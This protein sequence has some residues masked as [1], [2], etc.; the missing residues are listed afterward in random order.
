[1]RFEENGERIQDLKLILSRV[2]YASTLFDTDGV[3]IRFMNWK[4][5]DMR[6]L[7]NIKSEQQIEQL[8]AGGPNSVQFAG[9]T[10]LG[11]E[12]RNQVINPLILQKARSHELK[13]PVLVITITDGQP[14][15]ESRSTLK[16]VLLQA[17]QEMQRYPQYGTSPLAFQFAQ[18]GNDQPAREFL[19]ELDADTT[20]G[21]IIDCTSS[22]LPLATFSSPTLSLTHPD[23]ENEQVE[24]MKTSGRE[25]TPD[26]WVCLPPFP[27][28]FPFAPPLPLKTLLPNQLPSPAHQASN[29]RNRPLLRCRRREA[30]PRRPSPST[31][32][33]R[34]V[35]WWLRRARRGTRGLRRPTASTELPP[36]TRRIRPTRLWRPAGRI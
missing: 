24:F 2:A 26:L 22:K 7:D 33:T 34:R 30:R 5:Y 28:L 4:P 32:P 3:Q 11:T 10:P 1:M 6:M 23:F 8:L 14:A 16:E 18:V 17:R 20:I 13:K 29:G 31:S 35:W 21:D 9:L 25:L 19:G 15:G 27:H 36:A 12:L